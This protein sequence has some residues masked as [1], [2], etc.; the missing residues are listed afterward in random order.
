[1]ATQTPLQHLPSADADPL[2]ALIQI[3]EERRGYLTGLETALKSDDV[4]QLR[5]Y[6]ALLVGMPTPSI[7][8]IE[9]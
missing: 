2:D 5:H 8:N 6:A 9:A 3:A 7:I 4:P 1:M